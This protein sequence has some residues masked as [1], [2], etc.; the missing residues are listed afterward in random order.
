[1]A[2][3]KTAIRLID[4]IMYASASTPDTKSLFVNSTKPTQYQN[5]NWQDIS[6]QRNVQIAGMRVSHNMVFTMSSS[7]PLKSRQMYFENFSQFKWT[8]KDTE[9]STYSLANTL[10]YKLNYVL[11]DIVAIYDTYPIFAFQEPISIPSTG[12]IKLEFIPAS[13]LTLAADGDTNPLLPGAGLTS[14]RGFYITV[15]LFGIQEREI[16]E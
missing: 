5:A 9:Y 4:T 16:G 10:P 13:G 2:I 8:I 14:N 1:M 11:G 3:Q 7:E 15:E 12:N 6:A